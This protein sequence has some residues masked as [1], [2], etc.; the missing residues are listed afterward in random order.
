MPLTCS[1]CGAQNPDG[2]QFCQSCGSPLMAAPQGTA[3]TPAAPAP[4]A[5]PAGTPPPASPP[6]PPVPAHPAPTH[7]LP[8]GSLLGIVIG[9]LGILAAVGI[10]TSHRGSSAP[11]IPIPTAY[12]TSPPAQPTFAPEPTAPSGQPT[13]PAAQPTSPAAQPTA[14]AEQPTLAPQPTVD[15]SQPTAPAEQPTLASQPTSPP[16]QPGVPTTQPSGPTGAGQ[17]FSTTTFSVFVP[18]EWQVGNETTTPTE[19]EVVLQDPSTAP[20]GLDIFAGQN[21]AQTDAGTVLQSVIANLQ[22][23]FPDAKQCGSTV[24]I[25]FGGVAGTL[26]P[27]CYTITPQGGAAVSV[28]ELAWA[29]TDATGA[30]VYFVGQTAAASNQAF[31]THAGDVTKTIVWGGGQ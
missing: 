26:V 16:A 28:A 27:I 9:V 7:R 10:L 18:S 29:A 31:F 4:T 8:L 17:T 1:H 21:T 23:K 6:P 20:N 25:T 11:T 24:P 15:Q 2:M 19:N 13:A 3:P 12:P 30:N 22:Q 14:P 5:P